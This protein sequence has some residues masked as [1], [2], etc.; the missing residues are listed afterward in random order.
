MTVRGVSGVSGFFFAVVLV[1]VA[2]N[3]ELLLEVLKVF[4][5][6]ALE[7]LRGVWG[8]LRNLF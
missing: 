5:G 4:F 8:S 2:L 6:V 7:W 1:L 3:W